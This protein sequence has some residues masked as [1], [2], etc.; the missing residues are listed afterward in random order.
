[1]CNSKAV[2][3]VIQ[4]LWPMLKF[5]EPVYAHTLNKKSPRSLISG[6]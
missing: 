1:M 6:A 4:K 2:G 5:L 3:L